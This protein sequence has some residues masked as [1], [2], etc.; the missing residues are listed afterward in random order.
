MDL[1]DQYIENSRIIK[2]YKK[3]QPPKEVFLKNYRNLYQSVCIDDHPYPEFYLCYSL[4]RLCELVSIDRK[5]YFIYDQYL[6]QSLGFFKT[7]FIKSNELTPLIKARKLKKYLINA[8]N[9]ALR[10]FRD[11]NCVLRYDV[12]DHGIQYSDH[13]LNFQPNNP[14]QL[15]QQIP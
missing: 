9:H 14:S 15:R 5:S 2:P 4:S 12:R 1:I 6:G 13:T 7:I 8:D 11:D 3:I 10:N